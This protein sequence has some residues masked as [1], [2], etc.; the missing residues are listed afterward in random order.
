MAEES[1]LETLIKLVVTHYDTILANG[2]NTRNFQKEKYSL[3]I[4]I[5]ASKPVTADV[6]IAHPAFPPESVLI[7]VI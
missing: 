2:I 1:G 5:I 3:N 6:I 4:E 7:H